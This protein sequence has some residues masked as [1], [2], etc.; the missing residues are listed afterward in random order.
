MRA[1]RIHEFGGPD[2]L[3]YE[4]A[5]EPSV[6]PSEVLVKVRAT[7]LNHLDLFVRKG[8]PAYKTPLPHILGS[9]IAGELVADFG[10][11]RSGDPVVVHP[12]TFCGECEYCLAGRDDLCRAFGIYGAHIPGG[13]AEYVAVQGKALV[14]K[15]AGLTWEEAASMPLVFMTAFHM[16][17]TRAQVRPGEKVVVLA[18][19][20]GVGIAAT[21]IAKLAGATVIAAARTQAKLDRAAELG[22]D[23]GV[24]YTEPDWGKQ[25]RTL[26]GGGADIVVEHVGAVTFPESVK[27][28][29]TGGRVV[30]CGATTGPES[31]FDL[32]VLFS[33]EVSVLGSMLG[34]RLDTQRVFELVS[35]GKLKPV[36]DSVFP[37]A[38]ARAAHE[39]LADRNVF[40][41]VVLT[42]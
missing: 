25:V 34:T 35:A 33:H 22:A 15:P 38:E 26:T 7:A 6:G 23:H 17:V 39:K 28:V 4:D 13:Y 40:G 21:Q 36:V 18:A 16:L 27:M 24:N 2:R 32:R 10:A 12:V 42:I 3:V 5:P 8:V 19:G 37:L 29:R 31:G 20:S 9:D 11:F 1:V 41:K 30:T 14:S